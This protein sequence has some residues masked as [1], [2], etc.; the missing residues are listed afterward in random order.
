MMGLLLV[1]CRATN[2]SSPMATSASLMISSVNGSAP[3]GCRI[4]SLRGRAARIEMAPHTMI[5]VDGRRDG[6]QPRA[7]IKRVGAPRVEAAARRHAGRAG[8]LSTRHGPAGLQPF[9]LFRDHGD[10]GEQ[11]SRVGTAW[12]REKGR[13]GGKS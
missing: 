2:I 12:T 3:R 8:R 4:G 5:A 9:F 10:R 6:V 13:G 11:H 7:H 1:R